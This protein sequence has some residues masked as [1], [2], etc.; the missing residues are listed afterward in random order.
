MPTIIA[1]DL[2][3]SMIRSIS[4]QPT[5]TYYSL[6]ISAINQFL[7]YLTINSRLEYV[8]LVSPLRLKISY[9]STS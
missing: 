5:E 2:S 9:N 1:F 6:A 8:S 3:L 7:D 4:N